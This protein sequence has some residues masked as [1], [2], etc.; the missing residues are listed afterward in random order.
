MLKL[1][2]LLLA[3]LPV[4][5]LAQQVAVFKP[6]VFAAD[7]YATAPPELVPGRG[8]AFFYLQELYRLRDRRWSGT[9][10]VQVRPKPPRVYGQA[11]E[12]LELVSQTPVDAPH[13]QRPTG[14]RLLRL[15]SSLAVVGRLPDLQFG[16]L[17]AVVQ[18]FDLAGKP[19]G[20]LQTLSCYYSERAWNW[21]DTVLVSDG[22]QRLVW[23]SENRHEAPA[24]RRTL[25]SVF[26]DGGRLQWQHE[27]SWPTA[28][29][30]LRSLAADRHNTLYLL[31]DPSH[32]GSRPQ[33]LAYEPKQRQL[34]AADL[35]WPA[36]VAWQAALALDA[37]GLPV[38]GAVLGHAVGLGLRNGTESWVAWGLYRFVAEGRHLRRLDSLTLPLADTLR[39]R[40][41]RGANFQ[42]QEFRI[43]GELLRWSW[44]ESDSDLLTLAFDLEERGPRLRWSAALFRRG[45]K[46]LMTAQET[47]T[48]LQLYTE[49]TD[50]LGT[51]RL[52]RI[53]S[54]TGRSR[55]QLVH[56]AWPVNF[57]PA[58]G[59]AQ[60]ENGT[61]ML[62]LA[63]Q[64]PAA[65]YRLLHLSKLTD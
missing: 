47:T 45:G 61:L 3:M 10:L 64:D 48:C 53:D 52:W 8:D 12:S 15:A 27:V 21:W 14:L 29:H 58:G 18:F 65:G 6:P 2:W 56:Q 38:V 55:R 40:Y 28:N 31:L 43:E 23:W 26:A 63:G 7:A 41:C 24:R 16:G 59:G 33:L 51:L 37:R 35:D 13:A 60:T 42:L 50:P 30:T 5:V 46:L 1:V 34:A 39:E 57:R 32:A 9:W 44:A 11:A 22:G 19:L 25:V 36:P 17:R 54:A 4:G 49:A 20:P 62:P